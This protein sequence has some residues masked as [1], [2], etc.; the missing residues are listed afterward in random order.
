MRRKPG[1]HLDGPTGSDLA[2]IW[3]WLL[4]GLTLAIECF[5]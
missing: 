1:Q 5:L 4:V 2:G 3:P